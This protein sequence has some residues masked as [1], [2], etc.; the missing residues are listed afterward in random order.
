MKII[1]LTESQFSRVFENNNK[2][3]IP[4]F[5]DGD[6]KE[7]PNNEISTT[8]N[9]TNSNGDL[10][11]GKQPTTDDFANQQTPQTFFSRG[12]KN[13]RNTNMF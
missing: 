8:T 3:S 1:K 12:L 7:Y 2:S 5:N 6:I 13:A 11:Y 9:I 4:S 10:M